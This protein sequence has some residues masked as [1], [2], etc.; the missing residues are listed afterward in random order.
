MK[1]YFILGTDTDCG[2][3]YVTSQ[4]LRFFNEKNQ[5]SLAI[6]PVAS[7]CIVRNN[8]LVSEDAIYLSKYQHDQ[9]LQ[10]NPWRFQLPISP[11]LAAKAEGQ[12]LAIDALV[13]YCR[14]PNWNTWDY[15]FIEGA[16]GLMVPLNE[17]ETWIDF[18][19]QSQIPIIL[20]VGMRLG[21]INHALLTA[22]AIKAHGLVCKG[23]I[24]NCIDKD[25]LMLPE[26]INTLTNKLECPLL[27]TIPYGESIGALSLS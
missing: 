14:S 19:I 18:L 7:G 26:N 20:V 2:K 22:L 3:T 9:G 13:N 8:E 10:I 27:T 16:G 5:K 23:W 12:H 1:S 15:L 6:K 4:L 25:M 11:H 24:A 17:H 21:C